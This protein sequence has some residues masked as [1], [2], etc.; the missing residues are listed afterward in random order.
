MLCLKRVV[1]RDA[2]STN[3]DF[4]QKGFRTTVS[5]EQGINQRTYSNSGNLALLRMITQ[6]PGS[7]LDC[8]CGAGDNAR[9]LSAAG[10]RITGITC[11]P[12]EAAIASQYCKVHLK[13]LENG[14]PGEIEEKYDLILLSHVLEHL[15]HPEVLLHDLKRVCSASTTLG[16]AVPNVVAYPQRIAFLSGHFDYTEMGI[17]DATHVHFYTQDSAA[18]LLERCGYDVVTSMADGAFPLWRLRRILPA[19]FVNFVNRIACAVSPG[20]FGFQCMY[21]AVPRGG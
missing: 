16:V 17:M 2:I 14:L 11:S 8:G 10:W 1:R 21:L 5:S 15:V 4:I 19:Q 18:R 20:L 7:L 3:V 12:A 13:D 6:P 9:I